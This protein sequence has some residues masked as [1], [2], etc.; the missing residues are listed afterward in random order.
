MLFSPKNFDSWSEADVREEFL[1]PLLANLGYEKGT[2]NDIFRELSLSHP[3]TAFGTRKPTDPPLRGAPDYICEVG[4]PSGRKVKWVL[5]AKNPSEPLDAKAIEQAFTYA[6]HQEVCAVY[7][8]VSNGLLIRIFQTS[9]GTTSP[10]VFEATYSELGEKMTALENLLSPAAIQR[11]W[12]DHALD[13]RKPIG[14]GLRSVG[15]IVGGH[16]EYGE[17]SPPV[18]RIPGVNPGREGG[19][20]RS[21]P[22]PKPIDSGKIAGLHRICESGHDILSL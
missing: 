12:K 10:P 15:Q 4:F 14:P 22:P 1:A 18:A 6:N 20:P 16:I 11:D 13:P 17:S 19:G 8:G 5:E 7:F 2:P 21:E 3:R 9:S